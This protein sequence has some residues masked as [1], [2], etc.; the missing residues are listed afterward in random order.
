MNRTVV[1][2]RR[3][4]PAAIADRLQFRNSGGTFYSSEWPATHGQLPQEYSDAL[5]AGLRAGTVDYV[6]MSYRTPIAWTGTGGT[7]IPA[8]R[9]SPTTSGHQSIAR[10]ALSLEP[11]APYFDRGRAALRTA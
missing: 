8:V 5:T 9:Y 2:N 11:S 1:T 6:V 4:A 7:V 10:V 3:T